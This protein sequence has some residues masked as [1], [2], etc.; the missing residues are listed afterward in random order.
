MESLE[1]VQ[2]I[3]LFW[4]MKLTPTIC[5]LVERSSIE[6]SPFEAAF[7]IGRYRHGA[8]D[9]TRRHPQRRQRC[10]GEQHNRGV[11]V[12]KLPCGLQKRVGWAC[13]PQHKTC[14]SCCSGKPLAGMS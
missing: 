6:N 7:V 9:S 8:L 3:A 11:G 1:T 12:G 5:W 10:S 14:E 4:K 13:A 2:N